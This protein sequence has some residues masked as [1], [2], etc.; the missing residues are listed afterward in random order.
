MAG[1]EEMRMMEDANA[2]EA[3][4]TDVRST[5]SEAADRQGAPGIL[6][7]PLFRGLCRYLAAFLIPAAIVVAV[8]AVLGITPFGD[9]SALLWDGRIQYKD[10][11]G[12]VW[13]VLHG[14]AG[15]GYS[16]G[17]SLGGRMMGLL[18]YC[19]SSPLNLLLVFFEK[20]QIPL[21]VSLMIVLRIGLCGVTSQVFIQRRFGLRAFPALLLSTAYALM[22]YNVYYCRN[23]MWLDGVI[24]LPLVCLGVYKAV[25]EKKIGLLTVSVAVAIVANWYTGYMV[26]LFSIFYC[27]YEYCLHTGMHPLKRFRAEWRAIGRYAAAMVMGVLMSCVVLL[28]AL[29][30]LLGGKAANN[31]VELTQI[32]H[33]D[34]LHFFSGFELVAGVNGQDY[35]VVFCSG[36]ILILTFYYFFCS[37]IGRRERALSGVFALFL[38]ES[39]CLQDLEL[40]WT[41]YVQSASYYFRFAF[42]VPFFM[43]VLSARAWKSIEEDGVQGRRVAWAAGFALVIFAILYLRG[44]LRST[45]IELGLYLAFLV[46]AAAA[47]ALCRD[48]RRWLRGGAAA[49][50]A[51]MLVFELCCNTWYAFR[52]YR[53]SSSELSDYVEQMEEVVDEL[54]ELADG[55]FYRFERNENYLTLTGSDEATCESLLL[56]YNSIEHYSSAYDAAVDEFLAQM[57]Y[58]DCASYKYLKT[59]TYWNSPMVLMDA[60]LSIR[61]AVLDGGTFGYEDAGTE[62]ELPFEGSDVYENVWALPLGYNVSSEMGEVEYGDDPYANQEALLSAMLGE[63]ADVYRDAEVVS[64]EIV[65]GDEVLVLRA[66]GDGPLYLFIDSD[67]THGA[68]YSQSCEIYVDGELLQEC[69]TRFE[70]NSMLLGDLEEGDEVEVRITRTNGEDLEELHVSYAVQLDV[71]AFEEAMAELSE[72]YESDLVVDGGVVSGTYSTDEDTTVFLSIPYEDCWTLYV[73]GE[74]AEYRELGGCFIGF[75]LTAGEHEVRLV[76][77]TPGLDEGAALSVAGVMMF[78]VYEGVGH[79]RRKRRGGGDAGGTH[80]AVEKR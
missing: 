65:D 27:M 11:L 8:M 21:F 75:D 30:S 23:F 17:K 5:A 51:V 24:M 79:V 63:D 64:D 22:E 10:Y 13:D 32:I 50:L 52:E 44:D 70:I 19:D 34:V 69:C 45:A 1:L 3:A 71:A 20:D 9:T 38:I 40:L 58:A 7:S 62:A 29:V 28:P 39:F 37:K 61:Y 2:G 26:C 72:G 68:L 47:I 42:V 46:L 49:C 12:Y 59:E 57:G 54:D 74:E 14:E 56:G 41:A 60:L 76:Y 55:S 31:T 67:E 53:Y 36:L 43:L 48:R 66:T 35:P 33:F 18:A 15:I 73:D 78:A 77:S 25:H 6:S 80:A 16:T 4:G